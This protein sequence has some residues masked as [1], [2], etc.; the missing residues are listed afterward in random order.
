MGVKN[1]LYLHS[2]DMGLYL[3]PYGYAMRTP[4]LQRFAEEGVL[5][6]KA[7]AAAPTCSPSRAALLTGCTPH[8]NGQFGLTNHGWGLHHPDW[9]LARYLKGH[10]F[11]TISVSND[12]VHEL[13]VGEATEVWQ[14][15]HNHESMESYD[16][17][18]TGEVAAARIREGL[19]EPFFLAVGWDATH[20]SKWEMVEA[21]TRETLGPVDDRFAAPFPI[22]PDNAE[23][24]REAALQARSV[25]YL[26]VQIGKVLRALE[27]AG[28]AAETLVIFVTDHG[29]GQPDMKKDL[30][31]F[32]T[33][34]AL[35]LRGPGIYGG[36]R[37]CDAL[38]HQCD[39]FP[40][41]CD[42]FGLPIPPWVTGK[43]WTGLLSGKAERVHTEIFTEQNY[44]GSA[45]P[46]RAVRT[47]RYKYIRHFGAA[48]NYR[49]YHVDQGLIHGQ[50]KAWGRDELA[51]PEEQLYDLALDPLER[52]NLADDPARH[53]M[54]AELRGKLEAWMRE[55]GDVFPRGALPPQPREETYVSY[56]LKNTRV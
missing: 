55:T 54:L 38:V 32:G 49:H 50:W 23:T 12:H 26:D 9:H 1:L 15:V 16:R 51:Y 31:D 56:S 29:P 8:Q 34:T 5:F 17:W 18:I 4:H 40:T 33:G 44:H 25:E 24:R 45:C 7:F 3:G 22:Y 36:G 28:K 10:G 48:Q 52:R 46:L 2:H 39:F 35:M 6:R 19:P 43:S 20:R 47:E 21:H 41:V 37:V 14:E 11:H 13:P 42:A 53:P 27:E 30:L